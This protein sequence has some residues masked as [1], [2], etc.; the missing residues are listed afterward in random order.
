MEA[1]PTSCPFILMVAK[2]STSS[3]RSVTDFAAAKPSGSVNVRAKSQSARLG[4]CVSFSFCAKYGSGISFA[5]C[6]A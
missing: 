3:R 2:Q 6:E 1:L 5:V 4:H